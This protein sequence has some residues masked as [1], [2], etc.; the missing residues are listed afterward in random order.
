M[1]GEVMGPER[2][3][4]KKFKEFVESKGGLCVKLQGTRGLPDRLIIFALEVEKEG[5]KMFGG[6]MYF[7]E[8]KSRKGKLSKAQVF[9]KKHLEKL[10]IVVQVFDDLADAVDFHRAVLRYKTDEGK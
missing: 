2:A 5:R 1:Q 3:I 10:G 8:F 4:E 9:W 7:V 6:G